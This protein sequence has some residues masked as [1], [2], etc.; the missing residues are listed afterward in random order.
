M[1]ADSP[2]RRLLP[3][4]LAAGLLYVASLAVT[5]LPCWGLFA[6]LVPV[7][8]LLWAYWAGNALFARRLWLTGVTRTQSGLRRWLVRGWL[9]QALATVPALLFAAVLL[10]L[11][12]LLGPEHWL[13]LALDVLLLSLAIGPL[14]RWLG[15]QVQA[16]KV[17]T[18]ARRWPLMLLNLALLGV[19]FLLLDFAVLGGP[20]SRG[21]AWHVVAEAAFRDASAAATCP[22]AGWGLGAL[23]AV[24]ALAWH[25]SLLVIPSL[26]EPVLRLAAWGLVLLQAGVFAWLFTS[27]LLGALALVEQRRAATAGDGPG[28]SSTVSTAFIYTIL[29]LALPY[30][31][32][33]HKL[34]QFDPASLAEQAQAVVAWTNPCRADP[35]LAALSDEL[36]AR[37]GAARTDA[38]ASADAAIETALDDFFARAE[39]GVDAYLDWYFTVVGE[40]QRLAAVAVGDM[41]AFMA[42]QLDQR[43]FADTGFE[44]WLDATFATLD[45]DADARL[46]GLAGSLGARLGSAA[47]QND[48]TVELLGPAGL[49]G[50]FADPAALGRDLGRAGDRR[51]GGRA[52]GQAGLEAGGRRCRRQARRQAELQDRG[53]AGRQGGGEEGRRLRGFRARCDGVVRAERAL[54]CALR[55]RRRR[56]RLARRGQGDDRDRR[57]ALSRRDARGPARGARRAARGT[58]GAAPHAPGGVNR[59]AARR[60]RGTARAALCAGAGVRSPAV[61]WG[62]LANP[63]SSMACGA[64]EAGFRGG[65][66]RPGAE[67]RRPAGR[68]VAGGGHPPAPCRGRAGGAGGVAPAGSGSHA[69][70]TGV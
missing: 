33:A 65:A 49:A 63:S 14:Q 25:A 31:Y 68:P 50:A 19:T 61:D 51:R 41:G 27:L 11:A 55:H 12:A 5:R 40:Y 47:E 26:P 45:A 43:L 9:V 13:L 35:A 10:A 58:R 52:D 36:D 1:N 48:C 21:Q 24:D 67:G 60:P 23:A 57:G 39:H 53:S 28:V 6:L 7:A 66:G 32:A 38:L 70:G 54:G 69:G 2:L 20:D 42:A 4:A 15:T 16:D 34:R 46:A 62:E 56:R 29:V 3:L 44:T 17:G 30:L 64:G 22:A 8:W 37:L 59:C 18:V